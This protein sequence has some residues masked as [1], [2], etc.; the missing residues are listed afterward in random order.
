MVEGAPAI[1]RLSSRPYLAAGLAVA[2]VATVLLGIL[3][4]GAM[5]LARESFLALG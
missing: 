5:H 2:V 3:P 4:G 1:D